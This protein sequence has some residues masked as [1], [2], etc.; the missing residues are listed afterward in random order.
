MSLP[1]TALASVWPPEPEWPFGI[2]PTAHAK[3]MRVFQA[4]PGLQRVWIYGSRARGDQRRESDIDL[5]ADMPEGHFAGLA[6]A[7][8]DLG[9]IYRIDL[10][11]WQSTLA[12]ELRTHIERDRRV[13]WEPVRA[14]AGS[15]GA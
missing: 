2:A 14:P 7:V 12:P 8:E 15:S 5:V 10:L 4:T 3:L 1:A 9:L 6:A 11:H 13:F